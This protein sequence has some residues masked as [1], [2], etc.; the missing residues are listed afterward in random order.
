MFIMTMPAAFQIG[1]RAEV[2]INGEPAT[3]AWRDPHTLVINDQDARR[4]L[5]RDEG[6]DGDEQPVQTFTCG[7]AEEPQS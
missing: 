1:D 5:M 3:L 6:L 2:H 7:D 4:I